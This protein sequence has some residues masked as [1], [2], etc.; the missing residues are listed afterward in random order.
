MEVVH[1]DSELPVELLILTV[2][3]DIQRFIAFLE[4][5]TV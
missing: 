3:H 4:F 2:I 5:Q 1:V